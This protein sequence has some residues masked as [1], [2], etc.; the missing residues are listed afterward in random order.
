[1]TPRSAIALLALGAAGLGV[2]APAQAA[3]AG[4][5]RCAAG[6]VSGTV[7]GQ[8]VAPLAA[9]GD[10]S[11]GCRSLE[12]T[13]GLPAAL[14]RADATAST[15]LD[16]TAAARKATSVASV[17]GLRI[18]A[19]DS[20]LADLPVPALPA[21]LDRLPVPLPVVLPSASRK[22]IPLVGDVPELPV[23]GGLPVLDTLPDL[24]GL[25]DL[26]VVGDVVS[27][28]LPS[29]LEIDAL[30]AVRALVPA[31]PALPDLLSLDAARATATATCKSGVPVLDG[32]TD[33]VGLK[34]LGQDLSPGAL[35]DRALTL[36]PASSIPLAGAELSK[37][38]LPAGLSFD[39][40]VVGPV[41]A[42]AVRQVL[43]SLPPIEIPALVGNVKLTPASQ[44]RSADGTTLTQR[45][46]RLQVS[47][48]GEDVVDLALGAASVAADGVDCAPAAPVAA[49]APDSPVAP[50]SQLAVECAGRP[51]TLV[52][53]AQRPEHVAL[54]GAVAEEHVGRT[55]SIVFAATGKQVATG[56][57]RP[58]GFFRAKAPLPPK[59]I[60]SSNAARYLAV[61]DGQKSP[62]LKLQRRM[63]I[64]K[65]SNRGERI[66][67]VGKITGPLVPGQEIVVRRRESCTSDV[68][69]KR[70]TP[71]RA[72]TWKVWLP[73]PRQGQAAVY[74][75]TTQVFGADETEKRFPTFTLPGYVSL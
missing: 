74:R 1:M 10:L 35:V 60:R 25:P 63:R 52:D 47:L 71:D 40:P 37:I 38:A 75:A 49:T 44:E 19:V 72:G 46:A 48:L 4:D 18:G 51:V 73:A 2:A 45:A 65:L 58:D 55:V 64:S 54:L 12:A 69:V 7:L 15:T 6:A 61:L 43:S 36:A 17:S 41:L 8:A 33:L 31:T 50:A 23:V 26:P 14:G 57:V 9:V 24:P 59:A 42:T 66:L 53:V 68:I 34:V 20:L 3:P 67:M 62:A 22:G 11:S 27:S 21:G 32:V 13:G 70:F 39:D 30:D 16:G 28:L 29:V 5:L 56:V